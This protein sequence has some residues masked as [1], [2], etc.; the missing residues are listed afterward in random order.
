MD[1]DIF[2]DEI[3]AKAL[4]SPDSKSYLM[5]EYIKFITA[6]SMVPTLSQRLRDSVCETLSVVYSHFHIDAVPVDP[7]VMLLMAGPLAAWLNGI[8]EQ[9]G[10]N[11]RE[12]AAA[13]FIDGLFT[14]LDEI[15]VD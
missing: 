11:A 15:A 13:V 14:A 1:I 6:V 12:E 9:S 4:D 2:I 10:V 7:A 3:K 5:S 8:A